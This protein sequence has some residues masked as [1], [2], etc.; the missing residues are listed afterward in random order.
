MKLRK[1][2]GLIKKTYY[3]KRKDFV[4]YF[5]FLLIPFLLV[6]FHLFLR[7]ISDKYS[8]EIYNNFSEN[9]KI[10]LNDT[11]RQYVLFLSN[12]LCSR[13][14]G[15]KVYVNHICLTPD[16]ELSRSFL[17]YA[18]END[19]NIFR[20]YKSEEQCLQNLKYAIQLRESDLANSARKPLRENLS[21]LMHSF[22]NNLKRG[23]FITLEELYRDVH[24][25]NEYDVLL[26]L[27]IDEETLSE[28]RK[29]HLYRSFIRDIRKLK[30]ERSHNAFFKDERK[31]LFFFNFVKNNLI[32]TNRACG[33]LGIENVS[34]LGQQN[35]LRFSYIFGKKPSGRA[36]KGMNEA[37][38]ANQ[39]NQA[40][41][42]N[43]TSIEKAINHP[44]EEI[45]HLIS[46]QN[47][48]DV[49]TNVTYKIRVGDY[50]LLTSSENYFFNDIN[51]NLKQNFVNFNTVDDF[52][53]NVY[54]NE[55]YYSSFFIVLE[56]HFNLFMLKY[57]AQARVQNYA[58]STN[59]RTVEKVTATTTGN[60]EG[61]KATSPSKN[62]IHLKDFFLLHM[63]MKSMKI[64]AF[65]TIE[66]N[67]F[68]MVMFLCVCLFIVNICFDIN[69]ERKIKMENFLFCLKINKYYYYFSWLLFYFIVLF[70]YNTLFTYV[71]Y[72]YIYKK[73]V[74]YF[75]LFLYMYMFIIN[76]LLFTVIC[77]HFS[78]NNAINYIASF[79]IFFLFSS[80]R[81]IIH[82][83][84]GSVLSF[85]VLII[86]H[87]SFCLAL[88]FIFILV[89]NGI[90]IS[91]PEMF[92]KFEN[93]SLMHLLF[94]SVFS[95]IL[96]TCILIYMI[97]YRNRRQG[98]LYLRRGS[99]HQ[100][101]PS[102][103][104]GCSEGNS[105]M[106]EL[107]D[108]HAKED[109]QNQQKKQRNHHGEPFQ[110][111]P[112]KKKRRTPLRTGRATEFRRHRPA[113]C[114]LVIK[115]VNKTYGRKHVLKNVSLTLRSNRIFVLLGENGSGKSTLINIITEMITEDQGE[116]HFIKR[117]RSSPGITTNRRNRSSSPLE[118]LTRR[119]H[120][121]KNHDI[122][123]SY[124]SQNVILYENLTFYE[125][126][127]I[128]LL[129]YNKDVEKYLKKKRTRKIMNDLDLEKY[130]NH[131]IK[132]LIDDVKKKI[133]IFIC[134]LVKRDVYILDEPF[135]ALDI[136][137]KTK[138]FKFFEKIKKNNIIFICTHD[139][140]EA[141]NF[142]N[143]IAVI[144][145]GEIIFNGTKRQFQK[146][147]DYKFVL[148]VRFNDVGVYNQIGGNPIGNHPND[149]NLFDFLTDPNA[150][151]NTPETIKQN[152]IHFVKSVREEN[153]TCFIFF[154]SNHIYCTY[155]IHETESL[156]KLLYVLKRF[157]HIL[158][159]ELKTI[160]IYYTYIYIYTYHE[161][162][163][164]LKNVED[165]DLR[166]LIKMDPLFY[167]F[168]DN[169]RYFNELNKKLAI[170][171]HPPGMGGSSTSPDFSY[172]RDIVLKGERGR[173][174]NVVEQMDKHV[175][176]YNMEKS[177]CAVNMKM[178]H[179]L[180]RLTNFLSTYV[181]PTLFL[182]IKKDLGNTSFYWY[183]FLV[184]IF[185]LSFGLLIIK[186]VSLFGKI[187]NIELDY[188]TIS[189]NH[190]KT[191]TL[192]YYIIYTSEMGSDA[193]Q[194][195]STDRQCSPPQVHVTSKW[196][197]Y[198]QGR[199]WKNK[200][201]NPVKQ[202]KNTFPQKNPRSTENHLD[203]STNSFNYYNSTINSLLKKYCINEK[204][205]YI[206]EII[207]EDNLYEH[208]NNYLEK[209]ST[210]HK[211]ISLGT[212]VFQ[213]N[214]KL[215]DKGDL[216]YNTD[217]EVK[218]N[219]FCN[220]TSIHSYAYY[221]NS[222]FNVLADFQSGMQQSG[223][224]MRNMIR[225]LSKW[226]DADNTPPFSPSPRKNRIDVINEPFPIKFHEY[227]LRDFYINMYVFLSIV[228]F[229]C[230]F[231]E[232]LRNE[233]DY[234]KVFENFYVHKYVHYL[235]IL[236]LEY[237][238]YLLY[239]IL[240]FFILYV[241][242]YREFV[243]PSF[244]LFLMLYGFNTFLSI[245]L[246]SSLYQHSYILFVFVNF[247]FC[248]I[249]SIVI[250]VLVILSYAYNNQ[251]LMNLSHVFVC[252]FRILDSF[253]LSHVLN[254]RSL[255]LN[256]KRHMQQIDDEL[257][258][259]TSSRYFH[260][261]IYP[262]HVFGNYQDNL[263]SEALK[264]FCSDSNS[265]FNTT[266]DF[267]FLIVNCVFYLLLLFYKLYRLNRKTHIQAGT[268]S[269]N[270]LPSGE[271]IENP[272]HVHTS[273][274]S[275]SS[276]SA[277]K[278]CSKEKYA[279]AVRHFYLTNREF[280]R[281][282][283][284]EKKGFF[285]LFT[286]ASRIFKLFPENVST[287][288]YK[289]FN[290]EISEAGGK[291][292][293][294]AIFAIPD[295]KSKEGSKGEGSSDEGSY[296]RGNSSEGNNHPEQQPRGNHDAD[297][298]YILKDINVKMKPYKIY[299]FS[300][301]FNNDLNV[302]YF[303]KF[304]FANG[305]TKHG[306][307]E[308]LSYGQRKTF[309]QTV[310]ATQKNHTEDES[311]Y[312]IVLTPNMSIYEHVKI[313]LTYKNIS[314]SSA[315]LMYVINLLMLTVNL[316]CDVHI[317]CN[318]LSGG[319]K[320]KVELIIN[321]L[322]DDRIIFLYKL[323]DNI[324]FC[325]QIYIN[326]ILKN[327]LLVNEQGYHTG[328]ENNNKIDYLL[329]GDMSKWAI[330]Y[331]GG[332]NRKGN[333][334]FE[335]AI[336]PDKEQTE[337][338][339]ISSNIQSVN[340]GIINTFI[341]NNI[342]K[343]KFAP[344][345]FVIYTHIY[346]D[347]LY[348]DYLYL[349]NRNEITYENCTKNMIRNFHKH[350]SFQVKLKGIDHA[351]INEYIKFFFCT[352]KRACVRFCKVMKALEERGRGGNINRTG[353]R[354]NNRTDSCINNRT[355]HPTGDTDDTISFVEQN[356]KRNSLS[357]YNLFFIFKKIKMGKDNLLPHSP[358]KKK[359]K[360]NILSLS[361]F[362]RVLLNLIIDK[363]SYVNLYLNRN[364]YISLFLLFKFAIYELAYQNVQHFVQRYKCVKRI[365]S[366][367]TVS[368]QC[369]FILKI[370]DNRHFFKLLE[371]NQR[372]KFDD[373]DIQVQQVDINNLNANDIFLLLFKKLL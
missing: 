192:N 24:P 363:S 325:S 272:T 45:N 342:L 303:F 92:I 360:N 58:R 217:V 63:P 36:D 171:D 1:L 158:T 134:F 223:R 225:K 105:F 345:N 239:I 119:N 234:R 312:K 348:Y 200:I 269:T 322:R 150:L 347:I 86:P 173:C 182:M 116:I 113:D 129:Y 11:I 121:Q 62:S 265:F 220:Y 232:K 156:K 264:G 30:D 56:Y 198:W 100:I 139:I 153:K 344:R 353:R 59:T 210:K 228:I 179:V 204:I 296:N 180:K 39:A 67:I 298:K 337:E 28:V 297:E 12:E 291:A 314:L 335:L 233:I 354:T 350:Y 10:D 25:E 315:E 66:K 68:R 230:V 174:T 47:E 290:E 99:A 151:D 75:I 140:Y 274:D 215:T 213:I 240:L 214:E 143:D 163:N 101:Q 104:S 91:Y 293:R 197:N 97:H 359:K 20:V 320:K 369:L 316:R 79:L 175:G 69:K 37:N 248:G 254:I 2:Y 6:S 368:N 372:I 207:S 241:F 321:L 72:L 285:K 15:D 238:Y 96:L 38:Q 93:I 218:V 160:D 224:E 90:Q 249:I 164:L 166:N 83:G 356:S 108:G 336:T 231:F 262:G 310:Q 87:A 21:P 261:Q 255:C 327:I 334:Q 201:F 212:Y 178:P 329:G 170:L 216:D 284:T 109:I 88:D 167:L 270:E 191:S 4:L 31:K 3:E 147:I 205:K 305:E 277:G 294:K 313:I 188:S 332:P 42:A 154:N 252:I 16:D 14:I 311:D 137:T 51:I 44:T 190:M 124:C 280:K 23:K 271:E 71:I 76:S 341:K 268:E 227:F 50:A 127:V 81:L 114:Y 135:I 235:Q 236:L 365:Y 371:I 295:K 373:K 211:D 142:A 161:K 61:G 52:S 60:T 355:S 221:T 357:L 169:V 301:I 309:V 157:R 115:N 145:N 95:F 184:P 165:S 111:N 273:I 98:K 122:E 19:L 219:L 82:S 351:K 358:S 176:T 185:L 247:I 126:I 77:M 330:P 64:N 208:V 323:N 73:M 339:P 244:F 5:F 136:K 132:N 186:C 152:I 13:E 276:D 263:T 46:L 209:R 48:K 361:K 328:E 29:T 125:T 22:K 349:F 364:K 324:D 106:L 32:E 141:N 195:R 308:H 343:I 189:S 7:N 194:V 300:S 43:H 49:L 120:H 172:L 74:N 282:E 245:S 41:H 257:I 202:I 370:P 283:H 267:L 9:D 149:G 203:L 138:L 266:G 307:K 65:D 94:Y 362:Q 258:R 367:M 299:T 222:A 260:E 253:S 242:Q 155:K 80:F 306:P 286:F 340:E 331:Y 226:E 102:R 168:F 346:T 289:K 287:D 112:K 131:K 250:Y 34:H 144:K 292:D 55:W 89:K 279:F 302:L 53:L 317:N 256:M 118:K 199:K 352:N 246:F 159:Y 146:L 148:N 123:I 181:K 326:L 333:H 288:T 304:F 319:M 237:M 196:E 35:R 133:S 251:V 130:L 206:D 18:N 366:E 117:D 84:V 177:N 17:S 162:K 33:L 187:E 40:N 193:E 338:C 318:E 275:Q 103:Q 54:F 107:T 70:F 281:E 27:R 278:L 78:E 85:F 243:L 259:D 128:F 229:F 110:S 183:K 8:L 57:N 26:K